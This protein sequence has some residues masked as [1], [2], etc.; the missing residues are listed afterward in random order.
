[1]DALKVVPGHLQGLLA[2]GNA[3]DL[4][5]MKLLIVGGEACSIELLEQVRKLNPELRIVN[6][7][8]PSETTVG[9]LTHEI[10]DQDIQ[11]QKIPI[12]KPLSNSQALVF[13]SSGKL[14]PKGVAGELYIAGLSLAR[15]YLNRESLT[16]ERFVQS[17]YTKTTIVSYW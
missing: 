11:A 13:D 10:T 5:P 4:L 6:H 9:V 1:V 14:A 8:G 3:Q 2:A 15:G 12:G 7:Y 17:P 16:Q